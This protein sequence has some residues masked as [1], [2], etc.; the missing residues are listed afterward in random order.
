MSSDSQVQMDES[1]PSPRWSE[2]EEKWKFII[3]L[4]LIRVL[5]CTVYPSVRVLHGPSWTS[6]AVEAIC[7]FSLQRTPWS[8]KMDPAAPRKRTLS[9][10]SAPDHSPKR[11]HSDSEEPKSPSDADVSA[12]HLRIMD[13]P[14]EPPASRVSPESPPEY[15]D[16]P[17]PA[18][19][20]ALVAQLRAEDLVVGAVWYIVSRAWFR[21]FET[22]GSGELASKED[23]VLSAEDVGAIDNA[24]ITVDGALKMPVSDGRD[25][26]LVPKTAWHLLVRWCV[27]T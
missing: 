10:S 25:V 24:D 3:L 23:V 4:R 11:T 9:S 14:A 2:F 21:R 17:S 6:G 13:S 18:D 27:V 22:L 7:K 12:S 8:A 19:Q 15:D 26:V 5:H 1:K 20:L 16:V